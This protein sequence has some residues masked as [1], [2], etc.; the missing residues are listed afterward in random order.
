MREYVG[1]A[2]HSGVRELVAEDAIP[3]PVLHE[4]A[5]KWSSGLTTVFRA[6]LGEDA[7]EKSRRELAAG[8]PDRARGLLLNSARELTPLRPDGPAAMFVQSAASGPAPRASSRAFA[9]RADSWSF[10]AR[11]CLGGSSV[12]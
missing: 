3:G 2:D 1:L 10:R 6:V 11:S 7:A 12:R 9:R 5:R 4:L 8:R